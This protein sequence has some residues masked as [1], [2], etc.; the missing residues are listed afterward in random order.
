MT[1]NFALAAMLLTVFDR[2]SRVVGCVI[3]SHLSLAYWDASLMHAIQDPN[4]FDANLCLAVERGNRHLV[5][6]QSYAYAFHSI[7]GVQQRD[8]VQE[9]DVV[10]CREAD[11]GDNGDKRPD[12]DLC[13]PLL[14]TLAARER[15]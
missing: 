8:A 2:E 10:S 12:Y 3:G 5:A 9:S 14:E 7:A 15:C 13:E 1:Y 4:A 6:I 11:M